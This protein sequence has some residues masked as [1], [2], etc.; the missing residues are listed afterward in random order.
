M[1]AIGT[2]MGLH[3]I[4]RLP[5]AVW[6][7]LHSVDM[8][9]LSSVHVI[10]NSV[11]QCL[12]VFAVV[13][14]LRLILKYFILFWWDCE[15]NCFL[16]LFLIVCY[17]IETRDLCMTVLYLKILLNSLSSNS[18]SGILN[19]LCIAPCH[20]QTATD[21]GL[22]IG[23]QSWILV[24]SFPCLI[25]LSRIS[26]VVERLSCV[27]LFD[28]PWTAACQASLSFTFS[29][30]LLKLMSMKSVMS[31][32]YI[33]LCC[34]LLLLPSIF[35]GIRVFANESDLCFRWPKYWNFSLSC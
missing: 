3:W 17:C 19:F 1:S 27:H 16:N 33:I 32:N 24:T 31:S 10:L 35:P 29:Q 12:T 4:Y 26:S 28:T 18:F 5:W 14:L 34:P 22:P 21:L 23:L 20:L 9:Y 6:A 11:L 7:L 25:A 15:W 2:F 8:V 13:F 30:G